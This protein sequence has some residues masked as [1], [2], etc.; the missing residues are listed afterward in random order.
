MSEHDADLL[1]AQV[2]Q[3]TWVQLLALWKW[4]TLELW[5]RVGKGQGR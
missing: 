4:L 5:Q 1:R 3:M 2:Q